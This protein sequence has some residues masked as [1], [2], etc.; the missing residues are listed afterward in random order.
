MSNRVKNR[1]WQQDVEAVQSDVQSLLSAFN[2]VPIEAR[3]KQMCALL[4]KFRKQTE[5][6]LDEV[7]AEWKSLNQNTGSESAGLDDVD[8]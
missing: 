7:E 5:K 4:N 1:Q 6:I 2:D 8:N 3:S